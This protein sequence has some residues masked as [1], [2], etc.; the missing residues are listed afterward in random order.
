MLDRIDA[1]LSALPVFYFYVRY[2]LE[3]I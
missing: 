1:L 3:W 2:V